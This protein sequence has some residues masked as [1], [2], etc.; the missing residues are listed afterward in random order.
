MIQISGGASVELDKDELARITKKI[1]QEYGD[2]IDDGKLAELVSQE[3]YQKPNSR[4]YWFCVNIVLQSFS[5]IE[6]L[7][8]LVYP[9]Q[10]Q[11]N[12]N[13]AHIALLRCLQVR[14][15]MPQRRCWQRRQW[16]FRCGKWRP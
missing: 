2:D 9:L 13:Y 12:I 16:P 1:K 14:R 5:K 7:V 10:H 8:H 6:L 3:A 11:L 15:L 4:A